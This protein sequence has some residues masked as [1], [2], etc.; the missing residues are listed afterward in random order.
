MRKHHSDE[1]KQMAVEYYLKNKKTQEEISK[2]FQISR[3]TF[4]RWLKRYNNNK[5][6][7][8]KQS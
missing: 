3:Q 1:I 8:K 4:I 7:R 5:L 6:E 2:I